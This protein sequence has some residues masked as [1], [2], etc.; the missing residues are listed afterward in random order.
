MNKHKLF[1]ASFTL[2]L[3]V[4]FIVWIY[5]IGKHWD[6]GGDKSL[7]FGTLSTLYIHATEWPPKVSTLDTPYACNN[8]SDADNPLQATYERLIGSATYCV[9]VEAEG[10]AGST[11]RT[12]TYKRAHGNQTVVT[13][14]VLQYPQ[15]MNFDEPKQ[16]ECQKEE[17]N[18][19]AD[20]LFEVK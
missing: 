14:F 7:V 10:A 2:I 18:F 9:S 8:N 13:T 19:D 15:C 1:V 4:V 20:K 6:N 3:S 17:S 11:Y 5:S 16:S 12:Y